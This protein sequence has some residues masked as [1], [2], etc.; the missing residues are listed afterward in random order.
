MIT[1]YDMF[2]RF[3]KSEYFGQM[4]NTKEKNNYLLR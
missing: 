2:E 4:L 1:F 3:Q